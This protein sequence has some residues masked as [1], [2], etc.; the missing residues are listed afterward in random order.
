MKNILIFVSGVV[1]TFFAL[2]LLGF[3][4]DNSVDATFS[5]FGQSYVIKSGEIPSISYEN[6]NSEISELIYSNNDIMF[7]DGDY[8]IT[9]QSKVREKKIERP[10]LAK[11]IEIPADGSP[12]YIT[13]ECSERLKKDITFN[14][15]NQREFLTTAQKANIVY[16]KSIDT[17]NVYIL[18]EQAENG[19]FLELMDIKQK[20]SLE[21]NRICKTFTIAN[22]YLASIDIAD[23]LRYEQV[24][25][26]PRPDGQWEVRIGTTGGRTKCKSPAL[27]WLNK[28]RT[29]E[30]ERGV[31]NSK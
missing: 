28:A 7:D 20:K 1:A 6:I 15:I 13:G 14:K 4:P 3:S 12:P 17:N 23:H 8:R 9:L 2:L 31:Y 29:P 5:K 22:P 19:Y 27:N 24:I 18:F 11:C 26:T 30:Y 16:D 25:W 10:T 21:L